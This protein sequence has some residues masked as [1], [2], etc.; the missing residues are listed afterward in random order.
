M[1]EREL[2]TDKDRKFILDGVRNGFRIL[3]RDVVVASVEET[4]HK[5]A[6]EHRTA[7]EKELS[8]QIN[9]GNYIIAKQKPTIVSALAAIPKDNDK[10]RLIHDGSRPIGKAMNDYS[11]PESVKFQTLQDACKLAKTNYWCAKVD[12]MSAYRSV[13]IHPDNYKVTGLKWQFQGDTEPTYL[14]DSRLPFGSNVG[15]SH[16]HRLSQAVKRSMFRRGM[17][18]VVAYIDDFFLAAASKEECENMLMCLIQLLRELGFNISWHKV[19]GPTQ[20]LTFLGVDIDTRNST[21]SLGH[22]KLQQLRQRL[23]Q[24]KGKR[25]ATKRQLQSLAGSLNWACQAVRGG[26]FFV[27]RI[28]DAIRPLKQHNHKTKLTSDFHADL[29]WWLSFLHVFNGTVYL[30]DS[31]VHH[32][33]VDACDKAAG[34]FYR[35]DWTYTVFDCDL[36]AAKDLHI[37]YKEVCAVVL[38]VGRWAPLWRGERVIVH[39]DSIVTKC[40]INKGRSR[41]A[42][43]NCLLRKMAW[44]CAKLNCNISAVH[45][46]GKVNLMADTIS[47]LHEGKISQLVQLLS[48]YHHGRPPVIV[49]GCHMSVLALCFLL[50]GRPP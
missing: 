17:D 36:P 35:G 19:V 3:D 50:Q 15:P 7:V 47:R 26:R 20:Q 30:H 14:F 13:G 44:D 43:I 4:N 46:A 24:F 21:L 31:A 49:W 1:W 10:I 6:M 28:I 37:N 5:S 33:Y 23:L 2:A 12:L 27:R 45:V 32:I 39:T 38:A 48:F 29:Q 40:I 22:D 16:F 11:V 18:S 25:R 42:Y 9:K 34:A 41:N 8:D